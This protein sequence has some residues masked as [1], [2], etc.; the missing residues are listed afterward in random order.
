LAPGENQAV[1]EVVELRVV[2]E[3]M[4]PPITVDLANAVA[5][6]VG[7]R[8]PA[9]QP[10]PVTGGVIGLADGSRLFVREITRVGDAWRLVVWDGETLLVSAAF[11]RGVI[12][13]QRLGADLTYVSDMDTIGYKHIPFLS[14][15]WNYGTDRSASGGL[16]RA[17]ESVFVKGLGMHSIS[18]LAYDLNRGYRRFEAELALDAA[19]AGEGS[20]IFRV[21]VERSGDGNSAAAWEVAY[22][23]PLVRRGDLPL[24]VSLDMS[25][26]LRM[27]L[28]VDSAVRG[29]E[30]DSANWLNARL[31]K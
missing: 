13:A 22:E 3:G 6:N 15:S 28:V 31:M 7:L 17:G 19:A 12:G 4:Q 20:V 11:W 9:N 1:G 14:Q 8:R 25:G 24:P 16:L 29:D 27:A 2:A 10:Q 23:S 18:R 21:L 30:G 5:W 26:G